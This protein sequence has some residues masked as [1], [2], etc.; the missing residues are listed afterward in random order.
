MSRHE[1]P[2]S[3][4]RSAWLRILYRVWPWSEFGRLQHLA[5]KSWDAWGQAQ[6]DLKQQ[7]EYCAELQDIILAARVQLSTLDEKFARLLVYLRNAEEDDR[8][9]EAL[10]EHGTSEESSSCKT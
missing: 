10:N 3:K 8:K 4:W 1:W 5:G 6:D 7:Q 9:D 2:V